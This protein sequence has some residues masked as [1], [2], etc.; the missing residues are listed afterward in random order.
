MNTVKS[1][2]NNVVTDKKARICV[3]GNG[4]IGAISLLN[5][6]TLTR[7]LNSK[8]IEIYCLYNPDKPHLE[9][10]EGSSSMLTNLLMQ[11]IDFNIATDLD[12]TD[13]TLKWGVKLDWKKANSKNFWITHRTPG[14]HLD[15]KSFGTYVLKTIKKL[16]KNVTEIHDNVQKIEQSLTNVNIVCDKKNY[17]FDYVFDCQG[18]PALEKI[19]SNDYNI[20]EFQAV[21]TVIAYQDFKKYNEQYTTMQVH[22]NGW[23]FGVPLKY[24]KTWGYLYNNQ[25]TTKEE[26]IKG[27]LKIKKNINIKKIKTFSWNQYYKKT[28]LDGRVLTL[29]SKLFLLDP[30]GAIPLHYNQQLVTYFLSKVFDPYN[31]FYKDIVDEVNTFHSGNMQTIQDLIAL[32]YSGKS[33]IKSIFWKKSRTNAIQKLKNSQYFQAWV[34]K[35]IPLDR[36]NEPLYRYNQLWSHPEEYVTEIIKGFQVDLNELIS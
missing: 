26:A 20:P 11:S 7:C 3:I 18:T 33:N 6:C 4:T 8:Q 9:I 32:N 5:L 17:V 31:L 21:N 13:W 29:G 1:F 23:M 19:N 10:G 15:S 35:H 22:N 27:F 25:I 14:I 2:F 34:K 30:S 16:Y 28:A 24:K 12:S 36:V